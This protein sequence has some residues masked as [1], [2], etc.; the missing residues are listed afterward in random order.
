MQTNFKT[1]R[2]VL[3]QADTFLMVMHMSWRG[4]PRGLWGLPGGRIEYGEA[5]IDALH[6]E[7]DEELTVR[8][9]EPVLLGDYRYK[10]ARHQ[11]FGAE[12][13]GKVGKIDRNEIA[14]LAW[15][16]LPEIAELAELKKLHAGFE[17]QAVER[18]AE[19]R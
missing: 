4:R 16:T 5:G 1:A 6:R 13:A 9:A 17:A 10:G 7:L 3:A 12:L 11:I 15:L 19:L 14:D 8:V 18:Y 2:C